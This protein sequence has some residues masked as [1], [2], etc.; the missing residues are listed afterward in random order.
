MDFSRLDW[1]R[2]VQS[3]PQQNSYSEIHTEL[4]QR[5]LEVSQIENQLHRGWSCLF[6]DNV[7]Q[8]KTESCSYFISYKKN[9]IHVNQK[10]VPVYFRL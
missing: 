3:I 7:Y 5:S 4:D 2:S 8:A 1:R 6:H 10:N 9:D